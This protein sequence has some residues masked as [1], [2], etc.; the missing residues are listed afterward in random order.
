MQRRSPFRRFWRQ[1]V[2]ASSGSKHEPL[3]FTDGGKGG[4]FDQ[5]LTEVA[6]AFDT[7]VSGKRQCPRQLVGSL[8]TL[9]EDALHGVGVDAVFL[10]SGDQGIE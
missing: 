8:E 5:C 4:V 3:A 9:F 7:G 10:A 1:S 2:R 6:A